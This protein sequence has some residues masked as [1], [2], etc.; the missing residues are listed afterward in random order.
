MQGSLVLRYLSREIVQRGL[1]HRQAWV[2][3]LTILAICLVAGVPVGA[4]LGLLGV[5][6]G[7]AF[8]LALALAYLMLRIPIVG[9]FTVIGVICLLPFA[10]IPV[11]IGFTPTFLDLALLGLFFVWISRMATGKE[12]TSGREDFI[13]TSPT[14]AVLVFVFLA[15]VSFVAGLSHSALTANIIR[16][17]GE[18]LMSVLLFLLVINQVRTQQQLK[19]VTQVLILAGGAAAALGVFLYLIPSTLTVRLLSTLRVV[20][21]PSGD[22]VLRY[23]EEN[24]QL[25]LRA[26]STSVDPNVLGGLLIFVTT[27]T[28]TQALAKKPILPRGLLIALL[29]IMLF[30]MILTYSRGAAA[31]FMAAAF[32]LGILRYPK[33]L[34]IVLAIS[35]LILLLPPTQFY[36]QHFTQG[37]QGQDLATQMRFGEYKDALILIG[38]Y[39]WFGVGFASTPDIDT[40]LGVSSVYLLIGEEMG[41]IGLAAFL[42]CLV[43]L[44]LNFFATRPR[45][46]K[47]T[48]LEPLFLG[49]CLAV[50]GAMVGGIFDHYLFNLDFPHAAAMFWLMVGLSAVGIRLVRMVQ[51]PAQPPASEEGKSPATARKTVAL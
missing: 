43:A 28:V 12:A 35:L 16:H 27:L 21:Y 5:M 14:L 10:V 31:G 18:I 37:V 34:G 38:R 22:T 33:V 6:Y 41:L 46:P 30:C 15:M 3:G 32:L 36:V 25:P 51:L 2:R 50:A 42:A 4:V 23:I 17:F 1:S 20:G 19:M 45:C 47:D 11:D 29:A 26:T 44:A 40:Y 49:P 39:P 8:L 24:P 7:T 13:T 9:L 48:E